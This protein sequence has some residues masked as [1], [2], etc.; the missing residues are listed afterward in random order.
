MKSTE[1]LKELYENQLKPALQSIESE[2]LVL[3]K[4]YIYSLIALLAPLVAIPI[5]DEYLTFVHFA[6]IFIIVLAS[7]WYLMQLEKEKKVYRKKF[8]ENVVKHIVNLINPDWSYD[9]DGMIPQLDFESSGLFTA[10]IDRYAGDDLVKGVIEK[11]DFQFSEVKAEHRSKSSDNK[12]DWSTIFQ[13]L[14]AHAEFNKE[15]QGKTFVY[16]EVPGK[17]GAIM[18]KVYSVD[19]KSVERIKLENPEF[20]RLYE[21]YGT[22]QIESRYVL[23]PAMMEAM[24]NIRNRY[25]NLASFSFVGSKVYVA[26]SFAEELFEPRIFSTGVRFDDMEKMNNQFMIIQT[27]VHEMNLNTRI[28]T[29]E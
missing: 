29:K 12:V 8:K 17:L 13:G 24:V 28:W 5:F 20:E 6:I 4:K 10:R 19:T 26:M 9:S 1:E 25:G 14:F 21:V 7:I 18:G 2:R 23:T 27:I 11:T 22:S 3:R 15:I 16:P